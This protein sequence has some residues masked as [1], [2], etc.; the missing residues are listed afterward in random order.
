MWFDKPM[1]SLIMPGSTLTLQGA[2][3]EEVIHEV[4]L[5]VVIGM[6]GRN[7][8]PENVHRHIAGYF[9]GID[10]C[11]RVLQQASRKN[12]TDWCLAK[13]AD[14]FAAVSNYVHKSA[15]PDP[16]NVEVEIKI[17]GETR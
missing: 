2:I 6:R 14:E 10:F 1:T 9:V 7:I 3:H 5:G 15:I 16:N 8:R 13:G 12:T 4:E 17:N 11:N